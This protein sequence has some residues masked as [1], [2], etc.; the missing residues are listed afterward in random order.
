VGADVRQAYVHAVMPVGA[1]AA[2]PPD[3][4]G[5]LPEG[6]VRVH[7][8]DLRNTELGSY[9]SSSGS[10][11]GPNQSLAEASHVTGSDAT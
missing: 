2:L 5:K 8:D 4:G 3:A 7:E 10:S 11:S 1:R 9:Q 6:T